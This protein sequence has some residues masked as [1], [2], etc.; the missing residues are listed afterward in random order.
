MTFEVVVFENQYLYNNHNNPE[1]QDEKEA[2]E[3]FLNY[4]EEYSFY[5]FHSDFKEDRQLTFSS[6]Y[7]S[8]IDNTEEGSLNILLLGKLTEDSK[9]YIKEKLGITQTE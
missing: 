4:C 9:C 6:L 1:I 2:I 3:L 7:V 5:L 8:Y